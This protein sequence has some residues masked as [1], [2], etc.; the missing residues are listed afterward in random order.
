MPRL[1]PFRI[2]A[3][4]LPGFL[5]AAAAAA[6]MTA[7]PRP[8]SGSA[9]RWLVPAYANPCCDGG[10][11][12]WSAL[13]AAAQT[14][15]QQLAVIVNPDSGPGATPVDPNY[16]AAN[17]QGPLATLAATDALLVGYVATDYGNRP[18][19]TVLAEMTRYFDAAYWRNTGLRLDGFF[20][21]EMSN[22]LGQVGYYRQLRDH[23]RALSATALL[24]G[25]PGIYSYGNAS[26][27]TVYAAADYARVFDV[28]VL[29]EADALAVNHDYEP[30]DWLGVSGAA[31]VGFIAYGAA[32]G[33]RTRVALSR[34]LARNGRWLYVTDDTADNPYDR[35]PAFWTAQL[36]WLDELIFADDL[37]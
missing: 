4:L 3:L 7:L 31:D 6:P 36:G 37:E 30:P 11:A 34:M 10:P 22:D 1:P 5:S 17:G 32:T 14:R 29:H 18:L 27:Q 9:P 23:A 28:L 2:A 15:P 19:A 33:M 21:D 20:F 25:N 16:V 24:I 8:P 13:I 26:G 35:L 12:L